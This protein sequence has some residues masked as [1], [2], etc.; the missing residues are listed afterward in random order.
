VDLP[1]TVFI[2]I[3]ESG[4]LS[5]LD[6]DYKPA[7]GVKSNVP[8]EVLISKWNDIHLEYIDLM[9]TGRMKSMVAMGLVVEAMRTELDVTYSAVE[10]LKSDYSPEMADLLRRLGYRMKF[11]PDNK[12]QYLKDLSRVLSL[13]KNKLIAIKSKES[14]LSRMP[15][16]EDRDLDDKGGWT[17]LI[18]SMSDDVGYAIPIEKITVYEFSIRFQNMVRKAKLNA[19]SKM[20]LDSKN[21]SKNGVR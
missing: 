4:N 6:K 12:Q 16:L 9:D 19:K 7:S 20:A 10:I 11:D 15:M 21:K 3:S 18:I 1:L 2:E 14:E 5:L 17:K 13:S 8:P